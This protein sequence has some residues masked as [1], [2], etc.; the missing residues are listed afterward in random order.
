MC[1]ERSDYGLTDPRPS[2]ILTVT[3]GLVLIIVQFI[4][5]IFL[6]LVVLLQQKSAGVGSVFG[7]S[8][9]M[10]TTKRGADLIL[11]R[12]TI[13]FSSLFFFLGF[14]HLILV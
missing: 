3:M 14:L 4:V 13:F 12:V 11:F 6:T 2:D 10:T 7:G 1:Q 9:G 8:G 5:A